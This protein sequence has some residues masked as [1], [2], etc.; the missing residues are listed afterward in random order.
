MVRR[1]HHERN[2]SRCILSV[3]EGCVLCASALKIVADPSC[4]GSAVQSP[5]PVSRKA[6]RPNYFKRRRQAILPL[7]GREQIRRD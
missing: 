1:A 6:L 7:Q 4:G 2:S 3:V 5:S